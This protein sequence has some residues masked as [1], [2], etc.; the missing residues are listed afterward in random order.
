VD[1]VAF[2]EAHGVDY[3]SS[4]PNTKR[5]NISIQCPWCG[6]DDPSQ[7]LS[8]ALD[9]D[10]YGCWRN[11]RHAGRNPYPLVAA[12]LNCSFSQAKLIVQQFNAADPEN[13][14]AAVMA[15]GGLTK[16]VQQP[17][18]PIELPDTFKSIK[19]TGL[20]RRFWRYLEG[21]GF[22]DVA[23]LIDRYSLMCCQVGRWKDR[24]ILPIYSNGKLVGWT[25]RAIQ[26]TAH[27]PR[28]LTSS[29]GVKNTI[30]NE[31]QLVGGDKL[32]ITEGPFDALKVDFYGYPKARATCLFGT[33]PTL[34]QIS[35][36]RW[37]VRRYNAA[38]I[39]FDQQAEDQAMQLRDYF[40][41]AVGIVALP[42]GVKDPGS[43]TQQQIRLLSAKA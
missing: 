38:V 35:I 28:Y 17:E 13:L 29:P 42:T 12:L 10:A 19:P 5:G 8:V 2:L 16:P 6:P 18:L 37:V 43:L 23:S 4:G 14:E 36:L 33:N 41:S 1:W 20:T 15:L 24:I 26:G 39:L 30:F 22:D 34:S 9:K 27:A 25:A 21:R 3:V 40:S 32:F 7:H 11:A 31:D